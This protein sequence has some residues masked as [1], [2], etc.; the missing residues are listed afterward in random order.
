MRTIELPPIAPPS[1][2]ER[3]RRVQGKLAAMKIARDE[4]LREV[5]RA[6]RQCPGESD[7]WDRYGRLL[8]LLRSWPAPG[9]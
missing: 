5:W 4:A 9:R 1:Q 6:R 2:A 7:E 8:Q 3:L